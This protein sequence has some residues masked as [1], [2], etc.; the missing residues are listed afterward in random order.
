MCNLYIPNWLSN[1]DLVGGI[2]TPLKNIIQL[3]L[4]FPIYGKRKNVPVTTNQRLYIPSKWIDRDEG[5]VPPGSLDSTDSG[6]KGRIPPPDN[7]CFVEKQWK[8]FFG[9]KEY[10]V[11]FFRKKK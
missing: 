10:G 7:P 5:G 6:G 3:G 2:P 1:I 9:E 8:P 11:Y 4:L